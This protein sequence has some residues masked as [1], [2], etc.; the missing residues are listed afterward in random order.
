MVWEC[1]WQSWAACSMLSGSWII[2]S[3][4]YGS[5]FYH[6]APVHLL[7]PPSLD[8]LRASSTSRSS[9]RSA[10]SSDRSRNLSAHSLFFYRFSKSTFCMAFCVIQYSTRCQSYDAVRLGDLKNGF[11]PFFQN[12]PSCFEGVTRAPV[13]LIYTVPLNDILH[14]WHWNCRQKLWFVMVV[15]YP[16]LGPHFITLPQYI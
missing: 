12:L 3:V 15:V 14:F 13:K 6:A 8:C 1:S 11:S 16:S 10:I 7:F 5:L 4:L 9:S 2:G